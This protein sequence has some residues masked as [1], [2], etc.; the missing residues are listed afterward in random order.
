MKAAKVGKEKSACSIR[1]WVIL[2]QHLQVFPSV[3]LQLCVAFTL[4]SVILLAV[5]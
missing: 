1:A 3:S 2:R 5:H 4:A